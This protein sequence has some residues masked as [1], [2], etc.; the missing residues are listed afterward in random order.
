MMNR[1]RLQR[2]LMFAEQH[3]AEEEQHLKRQHEIIARLETVGCSQ[4]QTPTSGTPAP[5]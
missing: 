2:Q 5:D 3:V 1:D 4:S